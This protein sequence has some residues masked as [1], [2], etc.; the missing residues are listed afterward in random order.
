MSIVPDV[1]EPV[2]VGDVVPLQLR[3]TTSAG[4]PCVLSLDARSLL[5]AVTSDD[6]AIWSTSRCTGAVPTRSVVVQPHWST[7]VDMEWSGR[8]GRAGCD[9]TDP[10]A[11]PGSYTV[12]AALVEG[13]PAAIDFELRP[14]GPPEQRNRDS[15]R[16]REKGQT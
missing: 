1:S 5:V 9:S 7:V 15:S 12:Q 13:E 4:R 6:R 3:V 16:D 11:T 2:R 10:L 14:A 8:L